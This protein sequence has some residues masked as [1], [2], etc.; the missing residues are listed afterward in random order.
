MPELSYSQR[1]C[2]QDELMRRMMRRLNVDPA[3][4]CGVDGGLAWHRARTKCIFCSSVRE[5][6]D[7]LAA[8]NARRGP[9]EF[10]PNAD[11]FQDCFSEVLR[12]R[13]L[14]ATD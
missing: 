9:R 7:W 4:A 5:C 10:C 11:F 1:V 12:C 13:G 8:A 6:R 3:F 2:R 14:V